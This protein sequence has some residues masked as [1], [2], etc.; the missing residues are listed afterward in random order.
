MT[1]TTNQQKAKTMRTIH[2]TTQKIIDDL[3]TN[4]SG[5]IIP[6]TYSY[7]FPRQYV[8][9]AFR[10]AKRLGIIER[11]ATSCVGTPIYQRPLRLDSI[12][13]DMPD[14]MAGMSLADIMD[15]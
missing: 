15:G 8:S 6:A 5:S 3:A 7:A 10:I 11:R 9:A 1:Q 12:D 4:T 14:G 2:P 13:D